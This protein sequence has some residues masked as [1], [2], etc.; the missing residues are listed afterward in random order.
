MIPFQPVNC[1]KTGFPAAVERSLDAGL[2]TLAQGHLAFG[3]SVPSDTGLSALSP[4]ALV[5]IGAG[6]CEK[7]LSIN[8]T[9][10]GRCREEFH[11]L[12]A[13]SGLTRTPLIRRVRA[14]FSMRLK[15]FYPDSPG[16][17]FGSISA[18]STPMDTKRPTDPEDPTCERCGQKLV[19]VSSMPAIGNRPRRRIYKCVTCQT[20]VGIPPTD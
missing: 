20:V 19:L 7:P 1:G 6:W 10:N 17:H 2:R 18:M 4:L 14:G 13:K 11:R 12:A 8:R 9:F 15:S 3:H 5:G 16:L